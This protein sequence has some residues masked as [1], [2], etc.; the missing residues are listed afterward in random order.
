[1]VGNAHHSESVFERMAKVLSDFEARPESVGYELQG[2]F[3]RIINVA[4]RT[5]GW[6][7]KQ[8]AQTTGKPESEISELVHGDVNCRLGTIGRIMFAL[9]L[10]LFLVPAPSDFRRPYGE[11][12]DTLIGHWHGEED[13][14]EE[15]NIEED[16]WI[17][18]PQ[19]GEEEEEDFHA[20]AIETPN[21]TTRA[22]S[23][24]RRPR[25]GRK[26]NDMGGQHENYI[27]ARLSSG[28]VSFS[29]DVPGD[30]TVC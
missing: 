13:N 14:T 15:A 12:Q 8:L 3:S 6:T 4:L 22:A 9:D 23:G 28:N 29:Y 20:I 16:W 17:A 10:K 25:A 18:T 2:Q 24:T 26:Q 11:V 21:T 27:Q 30:F 7:Q 1:M 19:S 5:K